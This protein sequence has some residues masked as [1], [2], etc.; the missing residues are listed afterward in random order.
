MGIR[1]FNLY[2]FK[3][4]HTKMNEDERSRPRVVAKHHIMGIRAF[5]LYKF[6]TRHTKMNEDERSRPRVQ[7]G[8]GENRR[9]SLS[10]RCTSALTVLMVRAWITRLSN[11]EYTI[12]YAEGSA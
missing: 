8:Q 4:R 6:K 3:T 11:T 10:L 9:L 1:A 7:A 5:N 2:K 12:G